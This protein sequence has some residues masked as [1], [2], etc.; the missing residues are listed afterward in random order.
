ME[1][2]NEYI[3]II[4]VAACMVVGLIIKRLGFIPNKYIPLI[5]GALGVLLNVWYAGAFDLPV[6]V[7]GLA[8]GWAATGAFELV[9]NLAA[10]K[11]E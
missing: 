7:G 4:V 3:V 8:S 10:A 9:K 5:L 2:L 1:M 11:G 6:L